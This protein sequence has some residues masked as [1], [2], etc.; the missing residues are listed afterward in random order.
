MLGSAGGRADVAT[1]P[2]TED[3][4]PPCVCVQAAVRLYCT[5]VEDY[6]LQAETPPADGRASAN[7]RT[8]QPTA[9]ALPRVGCATRL[10]AVVDAATVRRAA[11]AHSPADIP[12][13][14]DAPRSD[15]AAAAE[16][17][18]AAAAAAAASAALPV[19]SHVVAHSQ[20]ISGPTVYVIES[21]QL[22]AQAAAA[23]GPDNTSVAPDA[24]TCVVHRRFSDFRRLHSAICQAVGL[25]Q[26]FPLRRAI[27]NNDRLRQRCAGPCGGR[28][29]RGMCPDWSAA[30]GTSNVA[31]ARI[32]FPL[33]PPVCRSGACSVCR[34]T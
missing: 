16:E 34:P 5:L 22:G 2:R 19:R 23:G 14:A 25:P 11:V 1:P 18:A 32:V 33:Q 9:A 6:R 3:W 15:A 8:E 31:R 7:V 20:S 29:S 13:S 24:R 4:A 12:R 17:A 10:P 26:A 30:H 21:V 28:T 27:L